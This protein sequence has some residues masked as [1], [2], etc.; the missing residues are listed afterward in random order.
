MA[1]TTCVVP[2][3]NEI[4]HIETLDTALGKSRVMGGICQIAATLSQDGVVNWS[5]HDTH[6]ITWGAREPSQPPTQHGA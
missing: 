6:A 3:L 4:S 2:L 1:A 5:M